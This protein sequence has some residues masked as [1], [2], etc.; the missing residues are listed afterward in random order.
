MTFDVLQRDP[1]TVMTVVPCA[2]VSIRDEAVDGVSAHDARVDAGTRH[3]VPEDI[4]PVVL[5]IADV[6]GARDARRLRNVDADAELFVA[7]AR[8]L[9]SWTAREDRPRD[10]HDDDRFRFR[11]ERDQCSERAARIALFSAPIHHPAHQHAIRVDHM[12]PGG[13][14][15]FNRDAP[16][17]SSTRHPDRP[18]VACR[19]RRS[20]AR[21]SSSRRASRGSRGTLSCL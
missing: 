15:P 19:A 8:V 16:R 2:V 9:R 4:T 12:R 7:A 14:S 10:E 11:H 17:P 18:S 13:I 5:P 1:T 20:R 21:G 6:T 3:H